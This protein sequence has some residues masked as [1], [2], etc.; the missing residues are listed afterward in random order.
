MAGQVFCR[1]NSQL[2]GLWLAV[3]VLS[4]GRLYPMGWTGASSAIQALQA[5]AE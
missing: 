5:R 1:S 4:K 3:T 2:T